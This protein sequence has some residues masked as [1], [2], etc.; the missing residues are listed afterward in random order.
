[1]SLKFQ[2][3][4]PDLSG[5]GEGAEPAPET[6]PATPSGSARTFHRSAPWP[7]HQRPRAARRLTFHRLGSQCNDYRSE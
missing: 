2:N 1:M 4:V 5:E 3:A 6:G 7:Q